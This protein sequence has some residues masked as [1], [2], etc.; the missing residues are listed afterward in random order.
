MER[1]LQGREMDE[2]VAEIR[3]RHQERVDVQQLKL[4]SKKSWDPSYLNNRKNDLILIMTPE[5]QDKTPPEKQ[6]KVPFRRI[7]V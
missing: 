5:K 3:M 1:I 7:K 6:D 4:P 2:S